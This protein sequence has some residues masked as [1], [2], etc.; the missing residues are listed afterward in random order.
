[1]R[2]RLSEA[3]FAVYGPRCAVTSTFGS[4][5]FVKVGQ[6]CRNRSVRSRFA[7][8]HEH[9]KNIASGHRLMTSP[10]REPSGT[11]REHGP[12]VEL[13]RRSEET[14]TV[15]LNTNLKRSF[16]CERRTAGTR[17]SDPT[18]ATPDADGRVCRG[19]LRACSEPVQP[20]TEF[21]PAEVR[22]S[23]RDGSSEPDE[24][25]ANGILLHPGARNVK[26]A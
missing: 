26:R 15:A 6:A 22:H 1:M 11:Q 9:W 19:Q 8:R 13:Q 2:H 7:K 3:A 20:P 18:P 21:A 16:A 4:E 5:S 12:R 25:A 23:P 17:S 14:R 24:P 10:A